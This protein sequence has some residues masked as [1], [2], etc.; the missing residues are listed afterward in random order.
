VQYV[1][2]GDTAVF[3]V[4]AEGTRPLNYQWTEGGTPITNINGNSPVLDLQNVQLSNNTD[5]YNVIV[6]NGINP[7]AQSDWAYLYVSPRSVSTSAQGQVASVA[8]SVS[9]IRLSVSDAVR[10]SDNLNARVYPG[11]SIIDV[12]MRGS[13]GVISG[14]PLNYAGGVWFKIDYSNGVTGWSLG[15]YLTKN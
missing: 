3:T 8:D 13:T 1:R 6:S 15:S 5:I 10:T 12:Q 9:S 11:G 7:P 4:E 2:V 14:G